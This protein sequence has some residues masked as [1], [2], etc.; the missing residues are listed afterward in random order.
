MSFCDLRG[1]IAELEKI[2]QL[3]IVEGADWR[4]EVGAVSFLAKKKD[5]NPALLFQKIKDYP[6]NYR[7]LANP[8]H[9]LKRLA[10]T[11]RMATDV[12]PMGFITTW[13]DRMKKI[14]LIP[15]KKVKDGPVLEN[16]KTGR[17]IDIYQFPT[18]KWHEYD[19]GRYIGTGDVV[20]TRD[21]DDGWVNLGT[22]R[23]M[24]HDKGTLSFFISPGKHGRIHRDKYFSRKENC[25]VAISFGHDPLLTMVAGTEVP[26]GVCEYDYAGGI[27]GF[28]VEVIEG[29]YS[30]L[31]IPA[32]SEL[33]I[34][35][36]GCFDEMKAEGPFG[37][38]TG[39]YAS[40]TRNEP[41]IKI[42]RLL[43]RDNPIIL[44]YP[45]SR[46][47]IVTALR[48]ALIWNELEMM[49]IPD[50]R[51][52][53]CHPYA[54][55][56]L[57]VII[58]IKQRYPGHAKQTAAIA[59]QCHAGAYL[60]RYVVVVDDDIDPSNMNDVVWALATRSDPAQSIDILRRCWSGPLDP[61]I[62]VDKK[63]HNSKAL[64]EA[65][66]PY[67]NLKDFPVAIDVGKEL[68]EQVTR[69][70]RDLF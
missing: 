62:P 4:N 22:Y 51:G 43:Y 21:P 48:A 9:S 11:L 30:G 28:P 1:F 47:T 5:N 44:G 25:K 45:P 23:V 27:C 8:V 55:H 12:T 7:I 53:W 33:V 13:K 26:Y 61:V 15:Q 18:P 63:G 3:K 36:E 50:I 20:V 46:G 10:L 69:K 35:G 56:R 68:A 66:R 16:V 29:E 67:E 38:W 52:V 65:T 34:E 31:P 2:D 40:S 49:G 70:W 59:S 19:G 57:F 39:Y 24:I 64:I 6:E 41:V 14:D 42:K 58:S 17:D 32:Y 37:E 60:G 54:G